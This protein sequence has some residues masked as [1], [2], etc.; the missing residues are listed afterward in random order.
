MRRAVTSALGQMRIE[1]H[2][3]VRTAVFEQT[4]AEF[5]AAKSSGSGSSDAAVDNIEDLE[6]AFAVVVAAKRRGFLLV[7]HF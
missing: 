2:V 3:V 6:T 5:D 1:A 4:V 7:V